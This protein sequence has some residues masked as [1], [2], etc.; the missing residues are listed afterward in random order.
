MNLQLRLAKYR[1]DKNMESRL[2]Y[3]EHGQYK[4][5]LEVIAIYNWNVS[6]K[7]KLK[8]GV[9]NPQSLV[10]KER[11]LLHHR[12]QYRLRQVNFPR[13]T[14]PKSARGQMDRRACG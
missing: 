1:F 14:P 2:E 9:P 4:Y 12:G 13:N 11:F 8:F 5:F 6:G 7:L 3:F 10:P